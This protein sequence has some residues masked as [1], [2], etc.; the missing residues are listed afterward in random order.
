MMSSE[1]AQLQSKNF[2]IRIFSVEYHCF[3]SYYILNIITLFIEIPRKKIAVNKQSIVPS[4]LSLDTQKK[5][6]IECKE[7]ELGLL[8]DEYLQAIMMDLIMKRKTEEKKRLII[9]QLVT[10][11]QEIDQDMQ[12]LIKIKTRERDIINLSLAQ[13]ETDAQLIAVTKCTGKI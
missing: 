13:K 2:F 5:T 11:E 1:I 3:I 8:Y 10:V 7:L 4:Q 12:K 6:D 9:T